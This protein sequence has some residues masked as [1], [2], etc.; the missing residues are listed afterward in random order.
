[1]NN[2][3]SE[4]TDFCTVLAYSSYTSACEGDYNQTSVLVCRQW[5]ICT[6]KSYM[7]LTDNNDMHCDINEHYKTDCLHLTANFVTI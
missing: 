2:I 6:C 4:A 3:T 5:P 7:M 1:M